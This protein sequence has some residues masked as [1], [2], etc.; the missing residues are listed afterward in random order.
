ME[1]FKYSGAGN[2]FV[3][4]DGR[5]QDVSSCREAG[6]V[7]RICREY[8]TDGLMILDS[9]QEYDFRMEFYNPDGSS[10]MMCGNGGRCIAAFAASLGIAPAGDEYVFEAPDGVHTAKIL[11]NCG[12]KAVVRLGMR[13]VA[14]IDGIMDGWFLN[15]GTRQFVKFVTGVE[16]MDVMEEGRKLRW[17]GA[18]AP[19]G[20]NVCFV[21]D[22]GGGTLKVRTFEKGVEGETL[23]CGTGIVASAIAAFRAGI[24]PARTE[25][26]RVFYD[27]K[28]RIDELSASISSPPPPLKASSSPAPRSRIYK[29]LRKFALIR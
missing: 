11:R 8:G 14:G 6:A 4:L 16:G 17:D 12:G 27:I 9:S 18:F 25:G 7:S 1:F 19:E 3:I 5:G 21:E 15:T 20:T 24:A 29:N 2:L 13:D 28:A 26:R 23:A 22:M 10:G